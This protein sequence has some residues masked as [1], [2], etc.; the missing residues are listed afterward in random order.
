MSET[1]SKTNTSRTQATKN[2][3]FIYD[4]VLISIS[5]AMITVCSWINIPIG[6][7]PFTLQTMGILAVMLAAGGRRGTMAICVYLAMGHAECLFSRDSKA[8]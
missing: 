4:L 8:E 7:I 5:A 1:N 2:R 3:A 6:P